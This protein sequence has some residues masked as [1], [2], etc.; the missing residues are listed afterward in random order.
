[1]LLLLLLSMQLIPP[2][3]AVAVTLVAGFAVLLP[4]IVAVF[5]VYVVVVVAGVATAVAVDVVANL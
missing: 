2:E 4:V 5:A 3:V 1:M